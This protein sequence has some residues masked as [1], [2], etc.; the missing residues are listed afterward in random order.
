MA[1]SNTSIKSMGTGLLLSISLVASAGADQQTFSPS[2]FTSVDLSKSL[3]VNF[4]C[5]SSPKVEARGTKK[6]L[7]NLQLS[8]DGG[9]LRIT[10][11]Q[12]GDSWF[13]NDAVKL[14]ITVSK[15]LSSV[16]AGLGVLLSV[17][18]CAVSGDSLDVD[19][20]MGAKISVTGKSES[21]SLKLSHGAVF[22]EN[23]EPF[24]VKKTLIDMEMG[25]SAT[26][27]DTLAVS[28]DQ[29]FGS[30]IAISKDTVNSVN[31]SMG[32]SVTH[33]TCLG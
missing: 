17:P 33:S 3:E 31:S 1:I 14:T 9:K 20:Y 4:R 26:L 30:S 16:R 23:N 28:G 25:A 22:N 29:S 27:C 12:F 2:Q 32:A 15:P 19:G 5:G 13:D 11:D 8:S 7:E 10:N 6:A 18:E 24:S 21:L